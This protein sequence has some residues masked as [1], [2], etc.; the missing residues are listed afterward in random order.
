MP[1]VSIIIPTLNDGEYISDALRSVFAQTYRDFETV[2][3]DGGSDDGTWEILEENRSRLEFFRQ[4]GKGVSQAKNEAIGK[5]RGEYIAFLD[6]DDLWYPDKLRIQ[7]EFL[8]DH[9]EF[10]FSSSDVDFFNEGGIIIKGAIS[11]EKEPHSGYVFDDM[12][13]NNFISSATIILR[14]GC[15]EKAGFFDEEIFYA[16]DTDMW[17]RVAKDFQLGYIPTSLAKYRVHPGAR[18]QE[19]IKHYGSLAGIYRK[20]NA[21]YP[22]YFEERKALLKTAYFNLYRRWGYRHFESGEYRRARRQYFK[23]LRNRPVSLL[24]WKYLLATFLPK[25]LI[26]LIKVKR[27]HEDIG[28]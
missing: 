25:Q 9:P 17:L 2:V 1:R 28:S 19:F 27:S 12:F 4:K 24:A 26:R 13:K 20:L 5:A 21:L 11:R 7:I 6:G 23:A 14:R 22:D 15:F 10:G 18:T 16:E 3:V 8:D